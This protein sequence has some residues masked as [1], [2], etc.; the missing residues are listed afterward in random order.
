MKIL[1]KFKNFNYTYY[2]DCEKLQSEYIRM[3]DVIESNGWVIGSSNHWLLEYGILLENNDEVIA[4]I[5]FNVSKFESSILILVTFIEEQYRQQG[6]YKNLHKLLNNIGNDLG[7][8]TVLA[9]IHHQNN[10]MNEHIIEKNGYKPVMT[11]VERQI[12]TSVI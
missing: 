7:K 8:K 2:T 5:F 11:L 3:Y 1:D 4:G 10:I 12:K 6:I 9:H